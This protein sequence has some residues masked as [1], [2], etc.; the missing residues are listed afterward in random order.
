[1]AE[2]TTSKLMNVATDWFLIL[3]NSTGLFG[4]LIFSL[5]ST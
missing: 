2:L 5:K 1:M 4:I 3:Y